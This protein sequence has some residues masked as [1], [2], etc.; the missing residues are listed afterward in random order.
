MTS[1][2]PTRQ[3]DRL[4]RFTELGA[5]DCSRYS[6]EG[7]RATRRIDLTH[8]APEVQAV[9]VSPDRGFIVKVVQA[10][11]YGG[12]P[13][14]LITIDGSGLDVI[15]EEPEEDPEHALSFFAVGDIPASRVI[16]VEPLD[17][18]IR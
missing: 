13:G 15:Q 3:F 11:D 18:V 5:E 17:G 10:I 1:P 6:A 16:S 7:V 4:Y 9:F 2:V 14:C 12:Q 8:V